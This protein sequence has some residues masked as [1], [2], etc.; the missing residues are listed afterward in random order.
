[1][2]SEK[3]RKRKRRLMGSS[4]LVATT[5]LPAT[6]MGGSRE[7]SLSAKFTRTSKRKRRLATSNVNQPLTCICASSTTTN[8]PSLQLEPGEN[9]SG[10]PMRMSQGNNLVKGLIS[11]LSN[12][13]LLQRI[14]G[15]EL[16]ASRPMT[17]AGSL[18]S[19]L[20]T[21][22]CMPGPIACNLAQ[23]S[24]TQTLNSPV[25]WSSTTGP[26]SR[27]LS[28]IYC[29]PQVSLASPTRSGPMS[30]W[31]EPSTWTPSSLGH[32][33]RLMNPRMLSGSG[34]SNFAMD[35]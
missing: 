21:S 4:T 31:E 34:T 25:G 3:H 11:R 17:P 35:P 10:L 2:P 27:M 19:G 29:P 5:S 6:E 22:N 9:E 8:V 23:P 12:P 26:T 7:V 20:R 32:T 14:Q 28:S 1:L 30:Y 15:N 18:E 16:G 33:P 13:T 24:S